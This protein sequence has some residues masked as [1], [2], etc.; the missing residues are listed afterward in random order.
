MP[1][2]NSTTVQIPLNRVEG[3]LEVRVEIRD[4]VVVDAWCSGTMYRGFEKILTGRGPLDGL[5]ITPR[6]CGICST[7]HLT[8]A[9]RALDVIAEASIP[10][11]AVRIRNLAL[12]AEHV[13]SDVRHAILMFGADFCNPALAGLPLFEEAVRRYEPFKGSA[14]VQT[15]KETRRP[16]EVIGILGGQWPH[17]GFMVPGGVTSLPSSNDLLQCDLLIDQYCHWYEGRILGC[18]VERWSAVHTLE[19]L[20]RW[21]EER[22]EHRQSEVGFLI[23]YA[24]AMGL[25]RLGAGHGAFVCYGSLEVPEQSAVGAPGQPLL[26]AAGFAQGCDVQTFDQRNIAEHV[27]HSWFSDDVPARHPFEGRTVP[28]AS[29]LE[30]GQRYSWA[31]APRYKGLPAETGPLAEMV[32][33]GNPLIQDLVRRS[34]PNALTRQLA[35]LVRPATLFAAMRTWL[36]EIRGDGHYYDPPAGVDQGSAAGLCQASRGALGHWVT[37]RD[38]K[39]ERYQIITPTA[40]NASPRDQGDVRGPMEEALVGTPVRDA[41]NPVELGFVVRSFDPCL[42]CTV[43]AVQKDGRVSR[44]VVG[45]RP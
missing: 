43:H 7:G 21:L 29:G 39:I 5:V 25:D 11:D 2:S 24:R 17:S 14:V 31:K 40:W 28:Y 8:A 45:A 44:T 32:I 41:A 36:S 16:V 18:T 13:Q 35:R 4:D 38:G 30:E 26:V 33:G 20:D 1:M 6:V 3:D 27:S 37:I 19:D 15:V 22:D 9:V 42:V 23:R 34:G 12:M 10:P